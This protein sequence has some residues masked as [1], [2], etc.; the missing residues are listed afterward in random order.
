MGET[1]TAPTPPFVTPLDLAGTAVA[2][3]LF[4]ALSCGITATTA[5]LTTTNDGGK[6][7]ASAVSTSRAPLTHAPFEQTL[8]LRSVVRADAEEYRTEFSRLNAL[9]A[10]IAIDDRW[11]R[12]TAD[13]AGRFVDNLD[14]CGYTFGLLSAEVLMN[15]H[16]AA[17]RRWIDRGFLCL[18]AFNHNEAE[19]CFDEAV[20]LLENDAQRTNTGTN[21]GTKIGKAKPSRT[22]L[23]PVN[24]PSGNRCR[25]LGVVAHWAA[26]HA[27]CTNYNKYTV[28]KAELRRA[29]EHNA[30]ACTLLERAR[31]AKDRWAMR[32]HHD[33]L[34][35]QKLRL[36][37]HTGA[38]GDST[39]DVSAAAF[40]SR[41]QQYAKAM[42]SLRVSLQ[43]QLT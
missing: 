17:A 38:S 12:P 18:W 23:D 26:A 19:A 27:R 30:Q 33:L 20:A 7:P 10:P 13:E 40:A 15:A 14:L 2:D 6:E 29:R 43:I 8:F 41:D 1:P 36:A 9:A 34:A 32:L 24:V 39:D 31:L 25:I 28:T 5:T 4:A 21:T 3:A 37:V 22:P 35:A 16:D 42:Q 11:G